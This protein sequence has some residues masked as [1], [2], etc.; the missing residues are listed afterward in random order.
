MDFS[1]S[2]PSVAKAHESNPFH[3]SPTPW[4]ILLSQ[5]LQISNRLSCG[6]RLNFINLSDDFKVPH[7][8]LFKELAHCLERVHERIYVIFGVIDIEARASGVLHP[9]S[10]HQ[11]LR[12]MMPAAH[13]DPR[14]I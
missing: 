6:N 9:K 11:R 10:S 12:T 2:D 1:L 5:T 4:T 7:T 8:S 14:F 3:L 13:C